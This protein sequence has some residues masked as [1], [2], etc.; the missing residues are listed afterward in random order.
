MRKSRKSNSSPNLQ[1]IP[2]LHILG[3]QI[4]QSQHLYEGYKNLIKRILEP[5]ITPIKL[6]ALSRSSTN[7]TNLSVNL[8]DQGNGVML[9]SSAAQRFERISDRLELLILSEMKELLA[10][11]E[12][13]V[14][15][16]RCRRYFFSLWLPKTDRATL[17]VLQHQRAEGL[18]GHGAPHALGDAPRQ[19]LGPLPPRLPHDLL[20]LDPGPGPRGRLLRSGLL[21]LVRRDHEPVLPVPVLLQPAA[22]VGDRAP[23]RL[24]KEGLQGCCGIGDEGVEEEGRGACKL[25]G[26]WQYLTY[27]F[28]WRSDLGVWGLAGVGVDSFVTIHCTI[29]IYS[30]K[31][32]YIVHK[33]SYL[34]GSRKPSVAVQGQPGH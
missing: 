26:S 20:L 5:K 18:G 33:Y 23:G 21:E 16:V 32:K 10:E 2:R 8:G 6:T 11:K 14:S 15:T 28:V 27:A 31:C 4:R 1:I 17:P 19:A 7:L 12:A 24:G 34:P 9:A 3:R 25:K 29:V 30:D 13:L 22:H